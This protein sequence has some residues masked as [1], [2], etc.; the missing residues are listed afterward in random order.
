M[1]RASNGSYHNFPRDLTIVLVGSAGSGKTATGN[2]ILERKAFPSSSA[3]ESTVL[4]DG[5][6]LNVIDTPGL[7]DSTIKREDAENEIVRGIKMAKDGIHALLLVVSLRVRFT[8]EQVATVETLK[9]LFG[10]RI[11][12]YMIV[13]FTGGDELEE[14]QTID[15]YLAYSCPP[16]LKDLLEKCGNRKVVFNNRTK[17]KETKAEQRRQLLTLIANIL[18][19]TGGKPYTHEV[20]NQL[21]NEAAERDSRNPKQK[22][23]KSPDEEEVQQRIAKMVEEKLK[24]RQEEAIRLKQEAERLTNELNERTKQQQS[25]NTETPSARRGCV[26]L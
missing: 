4:E 14:D 23:N 17:D 25:S 9:H 8:E 26:V 18:V 7:F 15:E 20:L 2:S 10:N 6:V 5:R 19:K 12:D 16:A 13:T 24:E 1:N 3:R 22:I 21:K 11:F